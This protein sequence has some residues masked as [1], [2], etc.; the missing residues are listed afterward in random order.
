[1]NLDLSYFAP[2]GSDNRLS[3]LHTCST[4]DDGQL[5]V[6]PVA[7][8]WIKVMTS[9][10]FAA[11]FTEIP[12]TS[13]EG[14]LV[15]YRPAMLTY[16]DEGDE[17]ISGY[18]NDKLW[19]GWMMPLF[20]K[21]ALLLSQEDGLLSGQMHYIQIVED[22]ESDDLFMVRS[23][24]GKLDETWTANEIAFELSSKDYIYFSSGDQDEKEFWRLQPKTIEVDGEEVAV[25]DT[26]DIGWT[27]ME[28]ATLDRQ[29]SPII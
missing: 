19:N 18:V 27:W 23:T 5:N 10:E 17:F 22:P 29:A 14:M 7:G 6:A 12:R 3:L 25:Y 20:T 4:R 13:I 9:E 28:L 8:G 11:E 15:D 24:D 1:M 16:L 21:E 2:R 26:S